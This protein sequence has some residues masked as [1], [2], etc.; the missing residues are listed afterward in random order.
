MI[1][2]LLQLLIIVLCVYA[3]YRFRRHLTVGAVTSARFLGLVATPLSYLIGF[4]FVFSK[5]TY[6]MNE[7]ALAHIVFWYLALMC[8]VIYFRKIVSNAWAKD[9]EE[10]RKL[11]IGVMPILVVVFLWYFS[12]L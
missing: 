9:P 1:T 5:S 8:L 12:G 10:T 2:L 7:L 6:H 4:R 3:A 11:G